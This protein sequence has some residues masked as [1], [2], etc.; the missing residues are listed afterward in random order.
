[1]LEMS[2]ARR[3][4]V[5]SP[6]Q[7]RRLRSFLSPQV[8]QVFYAAV[9]F[10]KDETL[11]FRLAP[12]P[13]PQKQLSSVMHIVD[14][15]CRIGA[16]HVEIDFILFK[17]S[18]KIRDRGCYNYL[19]LYARERGK[20]ACQITD[21]ILEV[22]RDFLLIYCRYGSQSKSLVLQPQRHLCRHVGTVD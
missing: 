3:E 10:C 18:R 13:P 20:L 11:I 8:L 2:R 21:E 4:D 14:E 22:V 17:E 1:M 5:M 12:L 19:T 6:E 16:L 15:V 9:F 7:F